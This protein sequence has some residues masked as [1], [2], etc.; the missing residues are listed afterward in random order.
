MLE[1]EKPVKLGG[2]GELQGGGCFPAQLTQ[3][4]EEQ[5]VD[6]VGYTSL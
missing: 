6:K 2:K 4:T 1:Q 3:D 5:G